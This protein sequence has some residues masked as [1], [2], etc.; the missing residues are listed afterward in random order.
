[1]YNA[2]LM[3]PKWLNAFEKLLTDE[4]VRFDQDVVSMDSPIRI[5]SFPT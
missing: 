5:R 3:N 4:A 1:M 2:E